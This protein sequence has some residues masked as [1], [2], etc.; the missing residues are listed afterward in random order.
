[1][2]HFV[3]KTKLWLLLCLGICASVICFSQSETHDFVTYD[4]IFKQGTTDRWLIRISRPANMFTTNHADTASRPVIIMMPGQ[5]ESQ[6]NGDGSRKDSA[7]LSAGAKTYGPHYWLNHGWDGGIQLGNGKHYPILIT[8]VPNYVNPRAPQIY[9]VMNHILSTYRIKQNSVHGTG[10]S[11]G[12]FSWGRGMVYEASAGAETFMKLIKSLCLLEGASAETFAPYNAW[13]RGLG[14]YG[15]AA[16]V[17]DFR[18]F[19]LEG[20]NDTRNVWQIR[21]NMRDSGYVANAYFAWQNI[22]GGGHCCW[23]DM[24]DPSRTNWNAVTPLGTNI[25]TNFNVGKDNTQGTYKNGTNL[26]T[27]MFQQGDTSMVGIA[28]LNANAGTDQTIY[29]PTSSATL[30]GTG[31]T[32]GI[33]SYAWSFES[34][35]S[36]P[37]ITNGSTSVATAS[38]LVAGSYDFRLIVTDG[39]TS[40]TDHVTINVIAA[41]TAPTVEAGANRTIYVPKDSVHLSGSALDADGTIASYLWTTQSGSPATIVSSTT[42]T[43][44]VTGLAAGVYIFRLTATDDDAATAYDSVIVTVLDTTAALK[45]V[46]VN[47]YGGTNAYSN[48][49]WNNWNVTASGSITGLTYEDGSNSG[50]TAAQTYHNGGAPYTTMPCADNTASYGG[51]MC[52]PEVLR[53]TS[54]TTVGRVLTIGGLST[55]QTNKLTFYASRNNTGNNT[56]FAIGLDTINIVTNSNLTNA[57]VFSGVTPDVSGNIVVFIGRGSGATYNYLN[58]FVI[59]EQGSGSSARGGSPLI[60]RQQEKPAVTEDASDKLE[61]YPN[62][63]VDVFNLVL[64]N[65]EKGNVVV[66]ISNTS[67]QSVKM[68]HMVKP[69]GRF[70]SQLNLRGLLPGTYLIKVSMPGYVTTKQII[71]L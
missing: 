26:F 28:P 8:V 49:A 11:M 3:Q 71:K 15:H 39:V 17:Y 46:N 33:T 47:V 25:T 60:A 54:Y 1:M 4:T 55:T 68:V 45:K 43:T 6:P 51:T 24:Y 18:V 12:A 20:T 50:Y 7:Q 2:K 36:T 32:G 57:A 21:N 59:E 41:N 42:A 29:L 44:A 62:P 34:G 22:G 67:G 63:T 53:Y 40:D 52:P 69:A 10:L 35:P 16:K 30:T 58:G 23:N 56:N 31:S 48:A 19:G 65:A 13:S 5:G 9:A 61:I 64:N 70:A 66:N 38:S 27:W 37:V 14:A